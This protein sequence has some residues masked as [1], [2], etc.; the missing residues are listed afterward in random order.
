M[1]VSRGK[2]W[3]GFHTVFRYLSLSGTGNAQHCAMEKASTKKKEFACIIGSLSLIFIKM[4][5]REG[6]FILGGNGNAVWTLVQGRK[7]TQEQTSA[8]QMA[9]DR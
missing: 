1:T 7:G 5:Q 2:D 6:F 3:R 4:K 8:P 9:R